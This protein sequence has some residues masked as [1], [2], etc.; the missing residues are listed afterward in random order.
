MIREE[1]ALVKQNGA[2]RMIQY[3]SSYPKVYCDWLT[4]CEGLR[5]F[6]TNDIVHMVSRSFRLVH[7][8]RACGGSAGFKRCEDFKRCKGFKRCEDF[9]RCKGFKR[10]EGLRGLQGFQAL[11]GFQLVD[12]QTA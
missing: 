1:L 3:C 6:Q 7:N 9:K 5:G 2:K 4:E 12:H 11:R 10:C 8:F